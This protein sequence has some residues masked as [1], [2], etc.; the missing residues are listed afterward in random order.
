MDKDFAQ[1]LIRHRITERRL[2]NGRPVGIR[3]TR[4]DGRPCDACDLPIPSDRK[5]VMVMVSLDWISVYFHVECYHLWS[6]E[7][8]AAPIKDGSGRASQ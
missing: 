5:A 2:P 8:E 3:E 6:E 4:G 1:Q 7:V